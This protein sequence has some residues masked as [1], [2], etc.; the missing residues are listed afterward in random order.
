MAELEKGIVQE[1][2]L[3]NGLNPICTN[4]TYMYSLAL[5]AS[6]QTKPAVTFD[7][8]F[9]QLDTTL[10]LLASTPSSIRCRRESRRTTERGM[11]FGQDVVLQLQGTST[12]TLRR[13]NHHHT[14]GK[15]LSVSSETLQ[16]AS[17]S[18]FIMR[19]KVGTRS[20]RRER[21]TQSWTLRCMFFIPVS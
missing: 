21:E 19:T 20:W 16:N 6:H 1:F 4:R 2:Y 12:Y 15:V 3:I 7:L 10:Q 18:T 5:A 13:S 9:G 14:Y 11:P 17:T 8:P